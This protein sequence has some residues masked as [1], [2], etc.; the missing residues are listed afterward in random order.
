VAT[1]G[2]A[3]ATPLQSTVP[4]QLEVD[5]VTEEVLVLLRPPES[6]TVSDTLY[7]PAAA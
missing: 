4:P 2:S 1:D 3:T 7:V 6:V 5:T